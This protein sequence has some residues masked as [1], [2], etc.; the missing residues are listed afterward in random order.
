MRSRS[1]LRVVGEPGAR[2]LGLGRRRGGIEIDVEP[3][4]RWETGRSTEPHVAVSVPCTPVLCHC[5]GGWLV[6]VV[7][8]GNCVEDSGGRLP[9][10]WL[11][12]RVSV[13][14]HG[15]SDGNTTFGCRISTQ[16]SAQV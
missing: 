7:G 6:V 15:G 13:L 4:R 1:R 3:W 16:I 9:F 12:G 11:A 5:S 2:G 8:T 10:R 14:P